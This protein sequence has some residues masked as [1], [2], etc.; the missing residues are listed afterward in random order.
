MLRGAALSLLAMLCLA[1]AD[2]GS[3]PLRGDAD[4][5]GSTGSTGEATTTSGATTAGPGTGDASATGDPTAASETSGGG[6]GFEVMAETAL[7]EDGRLGMRCNLPWAI[8]AC[9][10]LVGAPCEDVDA[11]GLVD[12]WEDLALELL[13]PRRRFDEEEPYFEDADAVLGDVGRVVAVDDHLRIFVMLGYS[14]DYGSCAGLSS[15]NG[16]SERVV[17]DLLPWSAAGAGGVVFES[18][19]TAAHEGTITDGS[20]LFA[21]EEL[22]QL[23]VQPDPDSQRPRWFVYPS[24]GKHATYANV[25]ICEGVSN[26]PCLDEDCNPDDVADPS[27]FDILPPVVNAGEPEA[28]RVDDLTELGFPGETAWGDAPFCGGLGGTGC[29]PSV[30]D[31]LLNDPFAP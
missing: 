4:S 5:D 18:A 15:H 2:D 1:C 9:V 11:D 16:D 31:K 30:R 19:Y 22:D 29:P 7:T 28:I 3:P 12:A 25:E 8:P 6:D 13:R 23:V 27:A 26:A 20:R 14:R 24:A 21:R 17:I 10:E